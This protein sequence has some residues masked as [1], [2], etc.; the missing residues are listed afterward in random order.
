MKARLS[1]AKREP[2][3]ATSRVDSPVGAN[4]ANTPRETVDHRPAADGTSE[5]AVMDVEVTP[6]TPAQSEVSRTLLEK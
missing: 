3:A 2:S 1:A 5:D 4:G 6:L